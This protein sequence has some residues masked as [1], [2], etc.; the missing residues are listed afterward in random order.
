MG[1]CVVNIL[2]PLFSLV[3]LVQNNRHLL[4]LT[5]DTLKAQEAVFEVILLDGEGSGRLNEYVA[6]YP[7]LPIRVEEMAGANKSELMNRGLSASRAKYVQF[8]TP[9]ERYL[10]QQGLS[11]LSELIAE[12]HEPQLVYSSSLARGPELSPQVV[13][14]PL[15]LDL[16]RRGTAARSLWFCKA[17]VLKAGGFDARLTHRPSFDLLCRLFSRQKVRAVYSRRVLTDAEPHRP[18]AGEVIG[19]ANE[20]CRI[21]YRHFGFWPALKWIFVQ[22]QFPVFLWAFAL[23]KQAFCRRN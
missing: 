1:E 9:G 12:G 19:Y 14:F 15:N 2:E 11:Y 16:L 4:P 8:L 21:V 23:L 13:N 10:S 17:A 18:F 3:V 20:T 6:S 22:D 7:E 5:L